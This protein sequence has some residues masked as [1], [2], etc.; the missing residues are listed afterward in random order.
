M[1]PSI[2]FLTIIT[3]TLFSASCTR[4]W[5]PLEVKNQNPPRAVTTQETTL[6]TGA[7]SF[8][9]DLFQQVI[10]GQ[11]DGNV[12][13]S[14]LSAALALAMTYNGA[15]GET[16]AAM[17]ET[18]GFAGLSRE[19]LNVSFQS[20]IELLLSLDDRVLL[21]I[22][23]SIWYRTGLP[24]ETDFIVRNQTY[25]D[26]LVRSL[27][28]SSPAAV[29]TINDWVAQKTHQRIPE[30]IQEIDP[31]TMM[32]LINAVYF[33]GDWTYQFDPKSTR[34]DWFNIDDSQRIKVDMMAQDND[35]E[36]FATDQFQ[37]VD[38]PY[39]DGHFALTILLPRSNDLSALLQQFN[40]ENW[41]AWQD[42]FASTEGTLRMPKF[43]LNYEVHLIPMLS[44]MGMAI[45]FDP[46]RADFSGICPTMPLSITDVLQKTFLQVD[47][48]GTEAAAVTVVVVGATSIGGP[49]RF[50]MEVNHPF[51]IVLHDRHSHSILFAGRIDHP[52]WN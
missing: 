33:K 19:D 45:A 39:G 31:L 44:A 43:K 37:A 3:F 10:S 25:Y 49:G 34:E 12:F 41:G 24:V 28:F 22:A 15:A 40:A 27:D 9:F 51:L 4:E 50:Y 1:K 32:I 11:R 8:G 46:H 26:A 23:Q 14:P 47:E 29:L 38:L 42:R 48:K 36:Y 16:E 18:L 13:I 5:S 52:A 6:V 30:I 21:D 20:L 17:R 7:N 35:F 2:P